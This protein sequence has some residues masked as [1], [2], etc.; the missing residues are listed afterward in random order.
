[1][2]R[3]RLLLQP[4]R[5]AV[6]RAAAT[7]PVLAGRRQLALGGVPL[8]ARIRKLWAGNRFFWQG[9]AAAMFVVLLLV[10]SSVVKQVGLSHKT[11]HAEFAQAAGMRPGATVDVSGIEVGTVR[12]V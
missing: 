12:A 9:V 5:L 2:L 7:R 11:I 3:Q 1:H 6:G 4:G 10:G 8:M